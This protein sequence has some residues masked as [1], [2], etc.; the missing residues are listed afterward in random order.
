ML[1]EVIKSVILLAFLLGVVLEAMVIFIVLEYD[2][3][4][5]EKPHKTQKMTLNPKK[6]LAKKKEN[7]KKAKEIQRYETLMAN[8]DAY[9]GT[10]FG[11][12]DLD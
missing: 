11:Q 9:D 7:T 4:R 1:S 6:I 10:D 8:I 2:L 3:H 5:E 12:K